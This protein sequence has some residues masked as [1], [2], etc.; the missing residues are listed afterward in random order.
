MQ[1][2]CA[3]YWPDEEVQDQNQGTAFGHINVYTRGE[4]IVDAEDL[5]YPNLRITDLI[6]RNLEIE[7]TKASN[8]KDGIK[9]KLISVI[10]VY[11]KITSF[12]CFMSYIN[13]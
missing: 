12:Y 13:E 8:G 11:K 4:D 10:S 6:R 7:D 1:P 9:G 5:G 3:Q 2:K